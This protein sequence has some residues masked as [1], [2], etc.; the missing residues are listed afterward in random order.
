MNLIS[1][2]SE[3]IMLKKGINNFPTSYINFDELLKLMTSKELKNKIDNIRSFKYKS[4]EYNNAKKRLPVVFFNK[5][6]CN[7][8]TGFLEEN[9]IKPFDVDLSD[10]N[11]KEIKR[12]EKEIKVDSIKVIKSP[13]GKGLKFF[14]KKKFNTS[15]PA[16]YYEKY[17]KVC[18]KIESNYKIKLDY[19]Q[20][21]IKQ[22]FF[23]TYINN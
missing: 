1:Y 10:N 21:R 19:C 20:G 5:F 15:D 17:K 23:L 3:G 16:V 2:Y 12:F 4:W 8:N 6:S 14:M 13:S 22:P 11:I 9:L 7:L 18:K